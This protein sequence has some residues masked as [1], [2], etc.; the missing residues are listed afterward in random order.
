MAIRTQ[1][2]QFAA[3]TGGTTTTVNCNFQGKAVIFFTH[4]KTGNAESAGAMFGIGAS[5]GT[6]HREANWAGDDAVATVNAAKGNHTQFPVVIFSNGTPTIPTGGSMSAVSFGS[7][8]FT[9][10]FSNTPSS[11]WLIDFILIG[12]EDITNVLV[13]NDTMPTA[14]GT[15]NFTGV[16]FKGDFI[17]MFSS[18]QASA[19][20]VVSPS[21][22]IGVAVSASKRWSFGWTVADTATTSAA[23]N[24]QTIMRTDRVLV[25]QATGNSV[26]VLADFVQFTSTGFDLSFTTVPGSAF[27]LH[28][29]VIKGGTWDAGIS[30]KPTGATTQT[31]SGEAFT[32]LLLGMFCSSP[33]ASNS[34]VSNATTSFG[35]AD[36]SNQCFANAF[37]NDAINT[38]AKSSGSAS[39][40]L[41]ERDGANNPSAT[42]TSF[43]PDG[44]TITWGATG[45][46][47]QVGWFTVGNPFKVPEQLDIHRSGRAEPHML[48]NF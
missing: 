33:T 28:Y 31:V 27:L 42:F 14:T 10:T 37:H 24:G 13:G 5:D 9:V 19:T 1:V 45:S 29:L 44:W 25:N 35:A 26:N 39:A 38:V 20:D 4:G 3:S 21:N 48:V 34:N 40:C 12:G 36:G 15:K 17:L 2:G 41:L 43:N 47:R 11:A 16:G 32:P 18:S 46:A 22:S 30:A 8:S 23:V 7:T 6:N